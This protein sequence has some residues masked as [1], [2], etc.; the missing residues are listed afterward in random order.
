MDSPGNDGNASMPE[1]V[2]RPNPWM[3]MM[4]MMMINAQENYYISN[5]G[6]QKECDKDEEVEVT[7]GDAT[8]S[9]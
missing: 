2:K 6:L 8:S 3:M 5:K 1:Q 7:A 9:L 4:R